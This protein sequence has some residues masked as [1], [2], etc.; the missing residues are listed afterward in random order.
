MLA[1]LQSLAVGVLDFSLVNAY[2]IILHV[3]SVHH[4]QEKKKKK[5]LIP[6]I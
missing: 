6:N 5:F 4:D 2:P 3:E 1:E